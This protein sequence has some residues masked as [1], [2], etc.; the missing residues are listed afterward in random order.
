[1]TAALDDYPPPGGY[2]TDDLD[3]LP[4]DGHRREL[5]DGVL[6]MSPSPTRLHQSIVGRLMVALEESCPPEYDVTQGVEIRI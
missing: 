5:L 1:M 3:A 6:L 4:E 2:T